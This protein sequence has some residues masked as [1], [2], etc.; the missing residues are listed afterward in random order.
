MDEQVL[1]VL[2]EIRNALRAWVIHNTGV[3]GLEPR[4]DPETG[5]EIESTCDH[6]AQLRA[7]LGIE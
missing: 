3:G 6:R 1:E 4:L 2:T 5:K 7:L